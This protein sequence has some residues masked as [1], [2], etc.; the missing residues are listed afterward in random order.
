MNIKSK[1]GKREIRLDAAERRVLENARRLCTE[2]SSLSVQ[3][4]SSI[5]ARAARDI[6][7]VLNEHDLLNGLDALPKPKPGQAEPSEQAKAQEQRT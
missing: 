4:V 6:A 3:A 1:N 2:L 5:A 7:D